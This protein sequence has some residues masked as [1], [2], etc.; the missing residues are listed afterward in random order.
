MTTIRTHGKWFI[1][2]S[3]NI[4]ATA[5]VSSSETVIDAA[6]YYWLLPFTM[7]TKTLQT[8]DTTQATNQCKDKHWVKFILCRCVCHHILFKQALFLKPNTAVHCMRLTGSLIGDRSMLLYV[9]LCI[10]NFTDLKLNVVIVC[11]MMQ[12]L[13]TYSIDC[14]VLA[15]YC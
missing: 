6:G 8:T 15:T 1:L 7:I 12:S 3:T 13:S 10:L 4:T 14:N 9:V 2:T 11:S 5:K